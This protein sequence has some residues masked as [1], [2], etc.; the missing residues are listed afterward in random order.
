MTTGFPLLRLPY[1]V[2]MPVLEQMEFTEKIA[3]SILSKRARMFLKLLR[4][5]CEEINLRLEHNR[6]EMEMF[7]DTCEVLTIRVVKVLMYIDKYQRRDYIHPYYMSLSCCPGRLP[8][9]AYVLPIMDVTHCKSIK[10]LTIAEISECD[11]LPLLGKLPRIDEVVVPGAEGWISEPLSYEALFQ[12]EKILLEVLKT[13]LPVSSA[14]DFSYHFLNPNHLREVLKVN[15]DSLILKLPHETFSLNDLWVTNAKTFELRDLILNLKDLNRF[16]KLWMK[17]LCNPRQEYL[18]V[19]M[20]GNAN[21]DIILDGLNAVQVSL[22]TKRTFPVLGNVKQLSSN[23]K[24]TSEFDITRIALSI[25]S[26]RAR[27]FLKLLRMQCEE[28]NLRLEHSRIEMKMFFN[29][30]EGLTIRAV[31]NQRR[32]FVDYY[33]MSFSWCPGRL[34]PMDY[35]VPI[36]D[37]T[38]CKSI[39]QLTIAK[40]SE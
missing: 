30:C 4:M 1:L 18:E 27:M 33:E 39:K 15:F 26:K 23:E 2:L 3:L 40:V 38:H 20:S 28:I 36:I 7:F 16:F 21:K 14:A 22:E 34:P 24:I 37:V 10:Q 17:K 11:T 31:K 13:V 9:I 6:I 35:A 12:R 25:L 8:P 32:D 19:K 5:Q 29:T